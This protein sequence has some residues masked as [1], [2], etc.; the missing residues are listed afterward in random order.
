MSVNPSPA[1][2]L[3]GRDA[4]RQALARGV[5]QVREHSVARGLRL[6]RETGC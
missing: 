5:A 3:A 4:G 2:W 1:A 6:A